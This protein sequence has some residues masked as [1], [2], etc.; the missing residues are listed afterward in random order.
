MNLK[1]ILP[2][3]ISL[4]MLAVAGIAQAQPYA[5]VGLSDLSKRNS[6]GLQVINTIDHSVAAESDVTGLVGELAADAA[7][8]RL[9]AI[10]SRTNFIRVIDTISNAVSKRILLPSGVQPGSIAVSGTGS[11]AYVTTST[12]NQLLVIDTSTDSIVASIAL[13]HS[14]SGVA[15]SPNGA[16]VYVVLPN[17]NAIQV[18]D[19]SSNEIIGAVGVGSDPVRVVFNPAG[20]KAY[21][22]NGASF[23]VSE[24]DVAGNRVVNTFAVGNSP[25][26]VAVNASGTKV[27]VSNVN[28]ASVSIIDTST[29]RV[30][31]VNVG[32][33]PFGIAIDSKRAQVYVTNIFDS[34]VSVIDATIDKVVSTIA[35]APNSGPSSVVII[36]GPSLTLTSPSNPVAYRSPVTLTASLQ[37]VRGGTVKFDFTSLVPEAVTGTLCA[38]V[39]VVAGRAVCTAPGHLASSAV[40]YS[41]AYS[42]IANHV[43]LNGTLRQ[44]IFPGSASLSAVTK[45]IQPIVGQATV[46]KATL[47]AADLSSK[48]TFYENGVPLTGCNALSV[49]PLPGATDIGVASCTVNAISAGPHRYVVTWPH[50]TDAGFEQIVVPVTPIAAGSPADYS[51]MWWAG[52]AQNGWGVSITQHGAAQF[53]VLYVYDAGGMPIWYVLPSGAWNATNTAFSG[54]LYQPTS[55]PFDKYQSSAFNVGASVGTATITYTS[56]ST[57]VMTY[58]INGVAGSKSIVRQVFASDDGQPK[59]ELNDLWWAGSVENGWGINIAQQGRVLFPVWYT[60]DANGKDVWYA[61]FDGVWSGSRYSGNLYSTVGSAWLGASYDPSRL[62]LTKVGTTTF[63]FSDQSNAVMTYTVNGLTQAKPILRQPF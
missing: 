24:I 26:G 56:N 52:A 31:Q 18:I 62:A 4:C 47:A 32:N 51:D 36:P 21:V 57:A 28:G 59:L 9:Y 61:V 53:I 29:A 23:D 20:S 3:I 30:G 43:T 11:R 50:A 8:A 55:A 63:D 38:A 37:G 12:P 58:T 2:T 27:Y 14:P 46:L 15:V 35:M 7:G 48:V 54:A 41:A 33:A 13:G 6:G 49:A 17:A 44:D 16:L 60:Y 40:V 45:P 1:A 19:A 22:T 5:Y 42:D 34:T 39:P 25:V 10:S